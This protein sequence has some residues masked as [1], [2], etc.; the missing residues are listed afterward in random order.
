MFQKAAFR[1]KNL[2]KCA[3]YSYEKKIKSVVGISGYKYSNCFNLEEVNLKW[4]NTE[5]I[6][7]MYILSSCTNLFLFQEIDSTKSAGEDIVL[8]RGK[9]IY[10]LNQKINSVTSWTEALRRKKNGMP[11]T[12]HAF[13]FDFQRKENYS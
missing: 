11:A 7:K 6:F 2:Y 4:E 3:V 8:L 13:M 12:L 5:T 1:L 10:K 9:K